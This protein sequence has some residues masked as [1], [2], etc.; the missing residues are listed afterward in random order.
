MKLFKILGLTLCISCGSYF[1]GAPKDL[2]TPDK[3]AQI[4][5][6]IHQ[7]EIQ[8]SRINFQAYDSSLVAFEYLKE[9][10]LKEF[11][12]DSMQYRKSYEYYASRPDLFFK[13]YEDIEQNYLNET[14]PELK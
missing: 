8:T 10:T 12:V 1:E 5:A 3:M 9:K 11:D 4:L 7:Y 2:I 14:T 13:I 6:K